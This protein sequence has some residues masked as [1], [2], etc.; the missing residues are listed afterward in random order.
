MPSC[1]IEDLATRRL[2]H[3]RQHF[4]N[5]G[6]GR[7]SHQDHEDT[8]E[9]EQHQRENQLD[10][11]LGCF[12]F[13]DL[14]TARTHRI[15]LHAQRLSDARSELIGLDKNRRQRS[16]V[17]HTGSLAQL[18]EYV[19]SLPSHLQL[20]VAEVQFFADDA[21]R[22]LHFLGDAA[23][24]LVQAETGLD[25]DDHQVERIGKAEKDGFLAFSADEPNDDVREIEHEARQA[26]ARASA[27][28]S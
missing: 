2:L 5:H 18:V 15:A 3:H 22:F 17:V 13:G 25:A 20:E 21:V 23:H 26:E 28:F 14:A 24:G 1:P 16:K 7:W 10:G 6:D 8:W 4:A 11:G 27:W 9:D 19:I 12:L